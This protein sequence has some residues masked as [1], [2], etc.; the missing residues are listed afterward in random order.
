MFLPLP[1]YSR[2]TAALMASIGRWLVA[3][4]GRWISRAALKPRLFGKL[5]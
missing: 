3:S 4:A 5:G 2:E 1:L